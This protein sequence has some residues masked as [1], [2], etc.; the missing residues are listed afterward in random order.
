M[1]RLRVLLLLLALPL[2]FVQAQSTD[3]AASFW[4]LFEHK[5]VV[6]QALEAE[7]LFPMFFTGGYHF[8]LGYRYERIRVRVS[9]IYGGSYDAEPA[10][11]DNAK[12]EFKRY[13]RPSPGI[14]LGYNVWNNL[15]VYGFLE[16]HTF[17]IEQKFTGERH[18]VRSIDYGGGISYQ[19]FIGNTLYFQPGI[20]LYMRD[21]QSLPFTNATYRLPGVDMAPVIRI[22][23]RLWESSPDSENK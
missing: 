16:R 7:S 11:I 23:L 18:D 19:F 10:G 22:G 14:F 21:R 3:S 13:Y 17:R 12:K 2:S 15:E 4:A 6:G 9:V 1:K 5:S 20:H 8:G